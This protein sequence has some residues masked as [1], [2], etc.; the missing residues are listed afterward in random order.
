MGDGWMVLAGR[1]SRGCWTLPVAPGAHRGGD[2]QGEGCR[3]EREWSWCPVGQRG[4]GPH[5]A[6]A[7]DR[8]MEERARPRR[9]EP[10]RAPAKAQGWAGRRKPQEA[11][12][13]VSWSLPCLPLIPTASARSAG[14][15]LTARDRAW[16]MGG[17]LGRVQGAR[18]RSPTGGGT[19]GR[20]RQKG[21]EARVGS[22]GQERTCSSLL[23]EPPPGD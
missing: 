2:D 10:G 4:R 6:E 13:G 5:G 1:A 15:P 7:P 19:G 14:A 8:R 3:W 11:G 20:Q 21:P 22:P 12:C 9:A 23:A 17:R 16:G 18:D